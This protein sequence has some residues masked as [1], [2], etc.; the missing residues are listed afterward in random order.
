MVFLEHASYF[1]TNANFY[2]QSV[3]KQFKKNR[4]VGWI[5]QLRTC[6][7]CEVAAVYDR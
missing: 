1:L 6:R 2:V 7:T 3:Y 5:C 4:K